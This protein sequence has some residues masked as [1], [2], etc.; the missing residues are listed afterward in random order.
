MLDVGEYIDRLVNINVD[1]KDRWKLKL[2]EAAREK[3]LGRPL[4]LLAAEELSKEIKPS[5]VVIFGTGF[6]SVT[7]LG[8]EQDGPVGSACLARALEQGLGAVPVIVTDEEQTTPI[9]KTFRGAGFNVYSLSQALEYARKRPGKCASV[10]SFPKEPDAARE[11]SK[12]LLEQLNPTALIAVERPSRNEVEVYHNMGGLDITYRHAKIDYLFEEARSR[13]ILTVGV[14]DGGNELGCGLIEEDVKKYVPNNA[15]CKCPCGATIASHVKA[16]VLVFATISD[17]GAYGI[18][19]NLA[20]LLDDPDILHT[21]DI[22]A[23]VL[24]EAVSAGL[25]DGS[26]GW[27]EPGSDGVSWRIERGVVE[28]LRTMVKRALRRAKLEK[29]P[30]K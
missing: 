2:Y 23:Q 15:R 7:L 1:A 11:E 4:C 12:K 13:G 3:Q 21:D 28:M 6:L 5:D 24:R 19:A 17:W 16:N 9:T 25:H 29:L 18:E 30:T 26:L 10:I 27:V 22:M 20:V 14:G 8:G